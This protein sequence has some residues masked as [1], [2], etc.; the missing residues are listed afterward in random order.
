MIGPTD[1]KG[2]ILSIYFHDPNGVRLEI[3][4]P[5]DKDWNNHNETAERDFKLWVEAKERAKATGADPV[6]AM[7]DLA[8]DVRKRY[9]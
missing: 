4:T 1:H 2:I 5:L 7:I 6:Q 9:G 8:R 3:T